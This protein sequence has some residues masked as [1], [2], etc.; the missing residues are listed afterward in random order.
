MSDSAMRRP[1]G[2]TIWRAARVAPLL[3]IWACSWFTD[4]KQQPKI[5]PWETSSDTIAF[6]GNPQG[7]VPTNGSAA[8]GFEYDRLPMPQS[9]AAMAKIPNPTPAD[10]ASV[11][12]GRIQFQINCEPCHGPLGL[13]NGPATKYGFPGI[14]IGAG[15]KAANEFTDG[16]IFGMIRNGRGV[17]PTYNRIEEPDRW[18]IINYLRTIQGK[19]T[20]AADTSHG[21]PGETGALVPAASQMGPT[22]PSPFYGAPQGS[23]AAMAGE[24]SGPGGVG[25][26]GAP[27]GAAAPDTTKRSPTDT[28]KATKREHQP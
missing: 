27:R 15:S 9:I 7:S 17:M 22:R 2:R 19:S 23:A 8:P 14:S 11:N 28:T 24:G 21:R 5:D 13:G 10:S 25:R 16:Y 6:R 26:A 12:R 20:I 18:D 4:F 1:I 3:S